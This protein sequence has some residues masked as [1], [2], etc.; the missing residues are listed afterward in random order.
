MARHFPRK[1]EVR[2]DMTEAE[3]CPLVTSEK[4]ERAARPA[5]PVRLTLDLDFARAVAP[6]VIVLRRVLKLLGRAFGVRCSGCD[7]RTKTQGGFHA[8][9]GRRE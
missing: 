6:P 3:R 2:G 5:R 9:N 8:T 1:G 7:L 4:R